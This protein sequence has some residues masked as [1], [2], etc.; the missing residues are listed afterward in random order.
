MNADDE[1]LEY[2][3]FLRC[4][5]YQGFKVQMEMKIT[6][7]NSIYNDIIVFKLHRNNRIRS[8][9]VLFLLIC[10]VSFQ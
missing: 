3:D 2:V 8:S 6:A 9:Y 7:S 5:Y 10:V 4:Y 1:D